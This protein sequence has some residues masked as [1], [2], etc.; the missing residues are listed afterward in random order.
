MEFLTMF[1]VDDVSSFQGKYYLEEYST[2][3]EN[4][5]PSHHI[6]TTLV[7]LCADISDDLD[8]QY[9]KLPPKPKP[10][11]GFYEANPTA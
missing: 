8:N 9:V 4:Q 6:L 1:K 5:E 2:F 10:K 7:W 3:T 11:M